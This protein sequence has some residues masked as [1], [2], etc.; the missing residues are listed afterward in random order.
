MYRIPAAVICLISDVAEIEDGTIAVRRR[1][2]TIIALGGRHDRPS[3]I[4]DHLP[5]AVGS[6]AC[7]GDVSS[8]RVDIVDVTRVVMGHVAFITDLMLFQAEGRKP[9]RIDPS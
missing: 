8:V 6:P 2:G 1:P 5:Q 9:G 3:V 4:E 7:K